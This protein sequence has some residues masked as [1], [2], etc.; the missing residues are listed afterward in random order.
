M[1]GAIVLSIS[2]VESPG[3]Y[4]EIGNQIV[5]STDDDS[6]VGTAITITVTPTLADYP[7]IVGPV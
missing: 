1:C 5:V 7:D 2:G 6:L 4:D 3:V